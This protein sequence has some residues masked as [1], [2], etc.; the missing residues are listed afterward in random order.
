MNIII[1]T[2]AS[3]GLG[4]EFA[5]QLD[6]L[7]TH[8]DEIWL[9]ARRKERMEEISRGL[10]MR[11]RPIGLDLTDPGDMERLHGMLKEKAPVIRME[12]FRWGIP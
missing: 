10:T 5:R 7:F 6:R 9:I 3:S 8:M 1:I 12:G 4:E 2:G 11:C